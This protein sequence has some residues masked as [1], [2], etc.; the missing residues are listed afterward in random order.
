MFLLISRKIKLND[1]IPQTLTTGV[2]GRTI[3]RMTDWLAIFV[4]QSQPIVN[5][6][7]KP[8]VIVKRFKF[9]YKKIDDMGGWLLIFTQCI[10][11]GV[12]IFS[13]PF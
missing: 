6:L 13:Q 11:D 9:S 3:G 7:S 1:L 4:E 12:L 10:G 8:F 5:Y 2:Y